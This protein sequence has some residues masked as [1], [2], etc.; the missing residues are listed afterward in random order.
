VLA[1]VLASL[2]GSLALWDPLD[3]DDRAHVR[4][5]T[6]HAAE[7][8]RADLEA[9]LR[10][11]LGS[12]R[13]LA[14]SWAESGGL[15]RD[16]WEKQ[17]QL[18]FENHAGCLLV[19]WLDLR[20]GSRW[21]FTH[22]QATDTEA[23]ASLARMVGANPAPAALTAALGPVLHLS[24]GRAAI[25]TLAPAHGSETAVGQFSAIF[26]LEV[27][28]EG[29]LS[30]HQE[31]GYSISVHQGGQ[32][33]YRSPGARA[34]DEREWAEESALDV[35][36][37]DW[38]LRVWPGAAL[39]ADM[40]SS[41]PE[42]ALVLGGLLGALLAIATGLAR[43]ARRRSLDL[44]RARDEV[45]RRV[46]ERTAEIEHVNHML[47][48]EVQERTQAEQG[49]RNLSTRL[50]KLQDEERRHLAR[51][52]HDSTT[53]ILAAVGMGLERARRALNRGEIE[54]TKALVQEGS[55]LVGQVAREIR[56]LSFLLHPPVLDDLGLEY[57]L[58]WYVKGFSKRSGI[59]V[60]VDVPSDIG[61]LPPEL[62]LTLYRTVQEGLANVHRHSG[63]R[64]AS[65]TLLR[66]SRSTTLEISDRGCGLQ[67]SHDSEA[68]PVAGM[69]VGI[70]G[71]R[72]R[73]RQLGGAIDIRSDATGTTVHV[74]LPLTSD[75]AR[76]AA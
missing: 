5:I 22:V 39:L 3:I 4:R 36:G 69:G 73:V 37:V 10:S 29:M 20:S 35:A 2:A 23:V 19:E 64:T 24:D 21:T 68:S 56:T 67:A 26:D 70:A 58:V 50:L 40:R 13:L 38:T 28:L 8:A 57:A 52:L 66:D 14:R 49:L 30:D 17:A 43:T 47:R 76:S 31:L 6:R 65:V 1:V 55:D 27:A 41:L 51:E 62:E 12:Q 75:D 45:E 60:S 11:L 42:L 71:M 59:V 18:F 74:V 44:G 16:E 53:Q 61:R 48:T 7:G 25:R 34:H 9:E 33:V 54:D 63:S 72:E 15:T 46:A 32:D